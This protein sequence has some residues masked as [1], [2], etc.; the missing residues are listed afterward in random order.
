MG[1]LNGRVSRLEGALNPPPAFVP[2]LVTVRCGDGAQLLV[3]PR[4][5]AEA[6]LLDG[7]SPA[8]PGALCYVGGTSPVVK[9]LYGISLED[10]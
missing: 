5:P 7:Q 3:W 9:T 10:V 4:S 1:A 2:R 6:A 8:H